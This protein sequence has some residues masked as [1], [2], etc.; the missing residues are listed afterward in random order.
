MKYEPVK[1]YLQDYLNVVHFFQTTFL[2]NLEEIKGLVD[3]KPANYAKPRASLSYNNLLKM[4]IYHDIH[5]NQ[6]SKSAIYL[7]DHNINRHFA[8]FR[9]KIQPRALMNYFGNMNYPN[10]ISLPGYS[11][12]EKDIENTQRNLLQIMA[13]DDNFNL[14]Y[15]PEMIHKNYF[16]VFYQA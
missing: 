1:L 6:V 2:M 10:R 15:T 9:P 8:Q 13:V 3:Y 7:L 4:V 5:F 12:P 14:I 16:V 11:I